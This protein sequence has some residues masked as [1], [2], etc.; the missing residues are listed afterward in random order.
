VASTRQLLRTARI[1]AIIR[2]HLGDSEAA[3]VSPRYLHKI[4]KDSALTPMRLLKRLR[5]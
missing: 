4:F 5:L 3:H 1:R 2:R